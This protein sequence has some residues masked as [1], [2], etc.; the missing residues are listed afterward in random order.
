M[1]AAGAAA[2]GRLVRVTGVSSVFFP[3]GQLRPLI[4]TRGPADIVP[5][6]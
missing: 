6:D 5:L 2:A 4:R 1:G 3:G